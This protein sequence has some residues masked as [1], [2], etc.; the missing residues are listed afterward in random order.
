MTFE[1]L[2]PT[3]TATTRPVDTTPLDKTG[4]TR[5]IDGGLSATETGIS[6]AT[7]PVVERHTEENKILERNPDEILSDSDALRAVSALGI[8]DPKEIK[9]LTPDGSHRT[10]VVESVW[11]DYRDHDNDV[12]IYVHDPESPSGIS[13]IGLGN[14]LSIN[15]I[16]SRV[17]VIQH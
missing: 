10:L 12:T 17:Q 3:I 16:L 2:D 9:V 6:S 15:N 13:K 14:E 1:N 7:R 11:N 4:P 8:R 5:K